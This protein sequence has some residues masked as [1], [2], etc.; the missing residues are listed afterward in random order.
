MRKDF[1]FCRADISDEN[2][3]SLAN[4]KIWEHDFKTGDLAVQ[5]SPEL[6]I[7]K[8]CNVVIRQRPSPIT[9]K[10][11]IREASDRN[12]G[13]TIITL[14]DGDPTE[15]RAFPRYPVDITANVEG[16]VCDNK[17]Y[18]L[19]SKIDVTVIDIGKGGMRLQA[20]R[21]TFRKGNTLMIKL[22]DKR[23]GDNRL[24]LAQN[25]SQAML[26]GEYTTYGCRFIFPG[27][28]DITPIEKGIL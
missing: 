24:V 5:Y 19:H 1:T 8:F 12:L 28:V 26:A 21:N 9:F 4:V 17:L 22:Q 6:T 15:T 11:K 7:G 13:H 2:G 23:L 3:K 18:A 10:A 20:N 14:L 27:G 16:L 25:V